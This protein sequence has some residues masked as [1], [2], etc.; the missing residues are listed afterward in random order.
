MA[1]LLFGFIRLPTYYD[2]LFN[3]KHPFKKYDKITQLALHL[4]KTSN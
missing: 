3:F 2:Q 1:G 4:F